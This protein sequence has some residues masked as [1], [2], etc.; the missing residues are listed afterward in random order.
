[1]GGT[2][3]TTTLPA[4]FCSEDAQIISGAGIHVVRGR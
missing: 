4:F 2:I 1:L 3:V